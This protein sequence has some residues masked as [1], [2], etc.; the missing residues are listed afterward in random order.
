MASYQL[1]CDDQQRVQRLLYSWLILIWIARCWD[2]LLLGQLSETP[3]LR[4]GANNVLWLYWLSDVP[5][6]IQTY[7][8]LGWLLDMSWLTFAIWGLKNPESRCAAITSSL[9]VL[10][11]YLYYIGVVT[12]HEHTLLGIIFCFPL[13]WLSAIQRF[14]LMFVGLRY[15]VLWV[16]VSAATWKIYRGS[17]LVPHQMAEILTDQHLSY[18]VQYPD[19]W[20]ARMLY[21]L[22]A[23]PNATNLLWYLGW[24]IEGSFVVGF[25]TRRWDYYLGRLF[26]GFFMVDYVLM[27]INFWEFCIFALVFYPWKGLWGHYYSLINTPLT[28]HE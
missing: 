17:W 11:Y 19:A 25:F 9:I 13:L 12:H 23:H 10:H 8:I 6:W 4:V 15:Y 1:A 28:P 18:L 7:P 20:Y 16:M 22:I 2:G 5:H 21:W 24:L 14:V 26:I 27:G 3:F